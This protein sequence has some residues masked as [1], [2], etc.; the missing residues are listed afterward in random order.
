MIE[1][2]AHAHAHVVSA[3]PP[4]TSAP[5]HTRRFH[6]TLYLVVGPKPVS[7]DQNALEPN[8]SHRLASCMCKAK[9]A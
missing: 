1:Q 7:V 6:H 5:T 4:P 8:Q 3:T 9:R 2:T